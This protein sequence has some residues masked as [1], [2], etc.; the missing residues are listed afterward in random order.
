MKKSV[1]QLFAR[2]A[3]V[4]AIAGAAI[5]GVVVT[6][7][8]VYAQETSA[9]V[10]G[11]VTD[12]SGNAVDGA[13]V[14]VTSST[15]G[16]SKTVTTDSDGSYSVRGLPAGVAYDVTVDANGLQKASTE[17]MLLAVGQSAVMNYR[18]SDEE[19]VIV[20]AQRVA[21]AETAIGPT[22]IFDLQSLQDS[23]AIN[24]NIND[25]IGQDP[26]IFIDQSRGVDSIQCNGA[27]PRF[28]SLTVDG[29]RLND[30][31]GLNSNGYHGS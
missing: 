6:S 31:F 3:L 27:N 2:K 21:V 5:V 8:S 17:G 22:A 12:L 29:I 10:R 25:I 9:M 7:N 11:V 30:G 15:T 14:V 23:P 13:T 18:L 26:R 19:E 1:A 20:V 16:I 28:N 24:R 4:S